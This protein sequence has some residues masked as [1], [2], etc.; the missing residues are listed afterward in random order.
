M[1]SAPPAPGTS[2]AQDRITKLGTDVLLQSTT[3]DD[4]SAFGYYVLESNT[5]GSF[6]TSSG[7]YSLF[8]NTTSSENT[9]NSQIRSGNARLRLQKAV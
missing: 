5:R 7:S 1:C 9:A 4:N 2:Q 6:N 8:A 3:G